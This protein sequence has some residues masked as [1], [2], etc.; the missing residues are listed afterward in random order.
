VYTFAHE[1]E[2]VLMK[3]CKML[4]I[5]VCFFLLAI[6]PAYCQRGTLGVDFGETTDRFGALPKNTTGLV[7]VDGKVIILHGKEKEGSPNLV[8][9]GE[10][11]FPIDTTN[12]PTEYALFG[13]LE[14][15]FTKSF[16]AGFHAQVR[17][18]PMPSSTVEGQNFN[19]NT[20]ELLE[21][22]IFLQ[23]RF[24]P[25]KHTF[26]QA[27]GAP[28]FHPRFLA[29]KGGAEPLP[30]PQ[31]DHAYFIRG[32][33]GYDFGKWYAKASYQTRYFK[34]TP[35]L[36]NPLGLYNWRSDFATVGIGVVF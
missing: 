32:S 4:L 20:F 5:G 1:G 31:F 16:T 17:K 14:F 34:F 21:I 23:Y 3:S 11:R 30:N 22:P 36:G 26:I 7:A 18:I 12:H 35:N 24:G 9:G 29:P 8:A 28:E 15:G 25:D 19:R 10:V 33:L 13:G 2:T 6:V 27:E